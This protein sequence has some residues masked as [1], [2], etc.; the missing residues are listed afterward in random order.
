MTGVQTCAL[1]IS[2]IDILKPESFYK[3]AHQKIFAAII[4]LFQKT[5]P[6]D[7]LTVTNQLKKVGEL[8]IGSKYFLM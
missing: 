6:V 2:V 4:E 5:E 3:E 7:I 8:D 1:P